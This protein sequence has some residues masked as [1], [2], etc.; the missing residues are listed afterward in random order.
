[1]EFPQVD[2]SLLGPELIVTVL[3]L[4]LLVWDFLAKDSKKPLWLATLAGLGAAI[5]WTALHIHDQGTTLAGMFVAD[6]FAS[7]FKL[8]LL[9]TAFLVVLISRDS[10][11]IPKASLGEFFAL[12][13]MATMGYMLMASSADMVMIFV[14]IEMASI[15]SYAL[16]AYA[17]DDRLSIEAGLKYFILGAVSSAIMLYGMS[18]LYGISGSTSVADIAAVLSSGKAPFGAAAVG[19]LLVLVGFA[20]KMTLVPFH[21]WVPDTY[22]GAPT[23]VTAYFSVVSKAAGLALLIRIMVSMQDAFVSLAMD[24]RAL[25]VVLS[26][27]TMI[28]GTVV[29]VVQTNVKRLLAY[30]SIAHVGYMFIGV[31]VGTAA[32]RESVLVYL[33]TYIFMTLGAFSVVTAVSRETGGDDLDHFSNLHRRAPLLAVAMAIFL[34]SMAGIPP[35]AG[36]IGKFKVFASAIEE[37][38]SPSIALAIVGILTSVVSL[39]FY[40][41]VLRVMY[42]I[43][44][45]GTGATMQVSLPMRA[46]V[47]TTAVFSVLICL[48][49]APFLRLAEISTAMWPL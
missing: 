49:P 2:Y 7:F 39:F 45:D 28:L 37:G 46:A 19:M 25:F 43:K 47:V 33:I 32:G 22:Q 31:A 16:A 34:V 1:M 24:W 27:I 11:R 26:A 21:M 4:V 3:A 38:S 6:P 14:A 48:Y 15:P 30:S 20:F 5:V 18:F 44:D 36:F 42:L 8:V 12:L 29:G 17:R 9:T 13:L 41:K 10:R 23:P 40:C 35:L